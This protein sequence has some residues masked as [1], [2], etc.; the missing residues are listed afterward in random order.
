MRYALALVA[1]SLFAILP[2]SNAG[3]PAAQAAEDTSS[4]AM[5]AR[6]E[7][8]QVPDRQGFDGFTLQQLMEKIVSRESASP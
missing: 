4:A 8:R 3:G 2:S 5:M 1:A 6:I 7:G